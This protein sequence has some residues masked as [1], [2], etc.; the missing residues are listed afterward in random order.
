MRRTAKPLR[1]VLA[2]AHGFGR[3]YL[4]VLRELVSDG[5]AVLSGVCDLTPVPARRLEGL[6]APAQSRD[7]SALVQGTGADVAVIATP[8]H[9]HAPLA[10]AAL[11]AGAHLMLEKPPVASLAQFEELRT[12]AERHRRACQVGFQSLASEA[13]AAVRRLIA[14]GAVGRV[15]GIGAA[16]AWSRDTAYYARAPWAGRRRLDDGTDVV[17]G[18]LTNPLAHAVATALALDGGDVVS[19]ETELYRAFDIEADDTSCVRVHTRGGV[20]DGAPVVVAAALTAPEQQPPVVTVHGERGRI[21]LEYTRDRVTLLRDGREPVTTMHR[22][23]VLLRDLV[24][25]LAAAGGHRPPGVLVPLAATLPFMRVLEAVRTAPGPVP[26]PARDLPGTDG[27]RRR[28][29][30]GVTGLVTEAAARLALFSEL[31]Q[32][33]QFSGHSGRNP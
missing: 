29:V 2:G 10:Q 4:P 19:V 33:P 20:T 27:A 23:A 8:L 24:A 32:F 22:R 21:E 14:D 6:G 26:V 16:A 28:V 12:A 5:A 1:I 25:R 31:P 9:T 18:A 17:D 15:R 30:P 3:N 11:A 13:P 7:L